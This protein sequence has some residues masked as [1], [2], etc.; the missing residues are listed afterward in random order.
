MAVFLI[1]GPF[2]LFYGPFAALRALA[3]GTI[4]TSRHPQAVEWF[5][6]RE[7]AAEIAASYGAGVVTVEPVLTEREGVYWDQ[8]NGIRIENVSGR[9]FRGK[10]ML[11][12][13]PGT[14][15]LALAEEP[16]GQMLT[17]LVAERGAAAGVNGGGYILDSDGS[18]RA[19][20]IVIAEGRVLADAAGDKRESLICL[21]GAGRLLLAEMTAAEAL[22]RDVRQAVAFEPFL[23]RDGQALIK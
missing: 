1:T 5:M 15:R 13:D 7:Q 17:R 18:M 4:L 9:S 2:I 10:V 14:V 3:I 12:S 19:D 8:A 21:D 11:I 16:A 20:G 6:P 22:E 23:I